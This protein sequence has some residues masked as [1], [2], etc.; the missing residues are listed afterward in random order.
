M[1]REVGAYVG[2][3]GGIGRVPEE[4]LTEG[5]D[6][7]RIVRVTLEIFA[8]FGASLGVVGE[9]AAEGDLIARV[10]GVLHG[11]RAETGD[12][13]R[14]AFGSSGFGFVVCERPLA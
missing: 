13:V 14:T 3:R 12:G 11:E 2:G 7:L 6:G 4:R 10:V 8:A 9:D 5:F 1:L